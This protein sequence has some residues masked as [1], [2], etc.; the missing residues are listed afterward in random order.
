[1]IPSEAFEFGISI[2]VGAATSMTLANG[3]LSLFCA[4]TRTK[5]LAIC[6]VMLVTWTACI[7]VLFH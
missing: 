4:A 1:M 7:T 3:G 2:M 5:V 6:T